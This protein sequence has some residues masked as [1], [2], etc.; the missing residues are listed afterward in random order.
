MNA[1]YQ[2]GAALLLAILS[3]YGL[4]VFY[5]AV[6]NLKRAKDAG[7]LRP[8]ARRFGGPVLLVGVLLDLIVNWLV[9][10]IILLELP[11]E[12]LVTARLK[13]H[14]K[15]QG[16]RRNV[17]YWFCSELLDTFDPSGAHCN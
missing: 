14:L 5:M 4:W 9:F 7:T 3:V 13:R 15:S 11:R 17:A 6:M 2:A 8:W 16:W 1:A 10:T 12:T